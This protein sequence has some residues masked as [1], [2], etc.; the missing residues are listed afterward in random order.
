MSTGTPTIDELRARGRWNPLWDRLAE[1]EPEWTELFLL[2]ATSPWKSGVL[3]AKTIELICIAGDAACTHLYAPGTRRHIRA[4]LELGATRDEILAVLKLT[5]LLGFQALHL[6]V[7]IL[8]DELGEANSDPP[9]LQ[10][11]Q[12]DPAWAAQVSL[13]SAAP[14]EGA[15]DA[16]TVELICIGVNSAAT[17]LNADA[18]RHHIGAAIAAGA[19][20]EEIVEV[21]KVASIVGIHACNL[22]VPILDEELALRRES[23]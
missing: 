20:R 6:A 14:R 3:P 17:H 13:L 10:L 19:T 21:L 11:F 5:S 16:K 15:L 18:V 7:P 12:W 23:A 22:A 8:A 4:A 9:L 1:W 2:A